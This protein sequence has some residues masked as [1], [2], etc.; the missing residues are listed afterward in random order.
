MKPLIALLLLFT[1]TSALADA[2]CG[3]I[4]AAAKPPQSDS[5]YPADIKRIDGKDTPTRALNR[6][7]LPVGKHSIA[8][9]EQVA[10]TP[11]GYTLLRKLGNKS[12]ALVYKIIEIEIEANTSYQIGAKLDKAKI[13]AKKPNDF[14]EPVVWQETGQ[15][16]G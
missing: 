15:A 4:S 11:R 10:S 12:T 3:Y 5:I 8:I 14:W 9:Q 2:A 7:P 16:C 13:D 1:S 6:Y